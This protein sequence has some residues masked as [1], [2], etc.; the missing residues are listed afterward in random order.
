[1]LCRTDIPLAAQ[2]VQTGHACLE[3]GSRFPQPDGDT[4]YLVLLA[5]PSEDSLL[6]AVERVNRAGV[7]MA[8]FYEPDHNLGHTA[9]CTEPVTPDRRILFHKYPAWKA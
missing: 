9:A 6:E 3:A 2:I 1:M 7:R 5:V 4:G 8:V